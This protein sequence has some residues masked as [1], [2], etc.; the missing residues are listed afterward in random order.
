MCVLRNFLKVLFEMFLCEHLR[1]RILVC[2]LY[3]NIL[4][5]YRS[6]TQAGRFAYSYSVFK[7]RPKNYIMLTMLTLFTFLVFTVHSLTLMGYCVDA[8][9]KLSRLLF[10][11]GRISN[12]SKMS[13][14]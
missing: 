2:D 12:S 7:G 6:E 4:C 13:G 14:F 5:L 11:H 1:H 9:A 8:F 3:G 10:C